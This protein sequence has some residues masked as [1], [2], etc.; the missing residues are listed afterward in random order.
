MRRFHLVARRRAV[1]GTVGLGVVV[2]VGV[3]LLVLSGNHTPTAPSCGSPKTD[4]TAPIDSD[5]AV[6]CLRQAA[7][8]CTSKA[9]DVVGLMN[10]NSVDQHFIVT[11]SD[12]CRVDDYVAHYT[13]GMPNTSLDWQCN[14]FAE[15]PNFGLVLTGCTPPVQCYQDLGSP[16]VDPPAV[17]PSGASPTAAPPAPIPSASPAGPGVPAT[18]GV[19]HC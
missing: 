16:I 6:I 4:H 3:L 19:P 12:H 9:L 14:A 15:T 11:P 18:N 1:V 10:D 17:V 8:T 5:P 13:G 7:A 2:L